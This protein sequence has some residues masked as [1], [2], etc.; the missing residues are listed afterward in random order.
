MAKDKG[1]TRNRTSRNIH[2]HFEA[3]FLPKSTRKSF[4]KAI[5]SSSDLMWAICIQNLSIYSYYNKVG[6]R[7]TE[8]VKYSN[9][10]LMRQYL[11]TFIMHYSCIVDIRFNELLLF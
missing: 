8:Y 2:W 3:Q 1:Y 10:H 6:G 7:E 9:F 4:F 5:S 11:S